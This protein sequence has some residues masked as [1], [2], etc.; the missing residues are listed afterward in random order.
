MRNQFRK[1]YLYPSAPNTLDICEENVAQASSLR[2]I[3]QE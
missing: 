3:M 2:K 1:P